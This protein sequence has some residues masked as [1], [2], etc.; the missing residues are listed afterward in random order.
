MHVIFAIGRVL[1]VLV[2][3][4]HGV[5]KLTDISG[6]AATIAGK[7]PIPAAVADVA[8]QLQNATGKSTDELLVAASGVVELVGGLLLAFGIGTRGVAL[9]LFVYVVLVTYYLHNFWDMSGAERVTNIIQVE[10]NVAL[11]G[12]LLILFAIGSWRTA[13]RGEAGG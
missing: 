5:G 11:M 9:V 10:K 12:G 8:T 7:V 13:W 4:I 6:T 2:F 3:I 1:F